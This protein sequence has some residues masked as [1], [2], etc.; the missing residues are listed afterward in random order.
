MN[1]KKASLLRDLS[2]EVRRMGAQGVSEQRGL[3]AHRHFESDLEC[4]DFIVMAGDEA[5][6]AGRLAVATG[7]T[8]GAI[9]GL[10]DR[11]EE[12][13]FVRREADRDD[14][15]KVRIL[16]IQAAIERLGAYYMPLAQRT[17]SLWAEYSEAQLRLILDFTKRSTA[18]APEEA[19]RI[20][21]LPQRKRINASA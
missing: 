7:L 13:G 12:A 5:I 3:R 20:R 6:T 16:P 8:T 14:R 2:Q 17:E 18:L 11:L 1:P 21:A 10:V 19:S 4:L 15:R 9:T